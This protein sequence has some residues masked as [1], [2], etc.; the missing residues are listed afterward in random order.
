MLAID[1]QE[2]GGVAHHSN[3]SPGGSS[4]TNNAGTL[5]LLGVVVTANS[6]GPPSASVTYNGASM[7]PLASVTFQPVVSINVSG[8]FLFGLEY[9]ALGSN[10]LSITFGDGSGPGDLDALWAAISFT[11]ELQGAWN[12][13]TA[14][15]FSNSLGTTASVTL[16]GTTS[17]NYIVS[18]AATG[19]GFTGAISPTVQSAILNESTATGGDNIILGYQPAGG[20]QIASYSQSSDDFGIVAMEI[21]AGASIAL[22]PQICM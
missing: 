16:N 22:M 10:A 5:L 3:T 1:S 21:A 19:T 2:S 20:T 13:Q 7:S 12:K 15:N 17:G 9:P 14:T 6:G 8:V 18:V 11:G 4:F